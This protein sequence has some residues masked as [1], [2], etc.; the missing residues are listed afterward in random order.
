MILLENW[1]STPLSKLLVSS[2]F[3]STLIRFVFNKE[4]YSPSIMLPIAASMFHSGDYVFWVMCSV[5]FGLIWAEH[6]LHVCCFLP[7]ICGETAN[8]TSGGFLSVIYFFW[9]LSKI[10]FL[11]KYSSSMDLCS[12]RVKSY[13][14]LGSFWLMLFLCPPKPISLGGYFTLR[15]ILCWSII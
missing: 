14:P 7:M 15:A 4:K 8:R 3:P 11:L 10:G 5:S 2:V 9:W 13:E 12:L 1:T 6:L